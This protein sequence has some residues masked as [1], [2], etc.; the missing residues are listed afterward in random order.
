ML[1][2]L[3]WGGEVLML[4]SSRFTCSNIPSVPTIGC[5][6]KGHAMSWHQ[7]KQCQRAFGEQKLNN[8]SKILA[9]SLIPS[10]RILHWPP[11]KRRDFSPPFSIQGSFS[12]KRRTMV[13]CQVILWNWTNNSPKLRLQS[14]GSK[15]VLNLN[16]LEMVGISSKYTLRFIRAS[17][18]NNA[19]PRILKHFQVFFP[20]WI[21]GFSN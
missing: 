20:Q 17:N 1:F 15:L 8:T 21:K 13:F 11:E 9:S 16:L 2:F 6:N 12:P 5:Q 4:T 10:I 19:L 18:K 3:I 7:P 14:R